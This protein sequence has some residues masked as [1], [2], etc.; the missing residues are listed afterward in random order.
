MLVSQAVWSVSGRNRRLVGKNILF[1]KNSQNGLKSRFLLLRFSVLL[2]RCREGV[3][4]GW[5]N[6]PVRMIFVLAGSR[7]ERTLYYDVY[8]G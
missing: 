1:R 2:A 7:D 3:D 5:E 6:S 4:F 8:T